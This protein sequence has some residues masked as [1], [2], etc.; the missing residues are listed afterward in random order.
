MAPRSKC[1][2]NAETNVSKWYQVDAEDCN[3]IGDEIDVAYIEIDESAV[4]NKLN[5]LDQ[6]SYFPE[7]DD[8]LRYTARRAVSSLFSYN[9]C[10]SS[11][12]DHHVSLSNLNAD[13]AVCVRNDDSLTVSDRQIQDNDIET[14]SPTASASDL[15]VQLSAQLQEKVEQAEMLRLSALRGIINIDCEVLERWKPP[16]RSPNTSMTKVRRWAK[17]FEHTGET[18]HCW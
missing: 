17:W 18:P 6:L 5:A 2:R 4:L 8:S 10:S 3:I 13:N 1:S 14:H 9:L 12:P 7:A 11:V 16:L 15:L